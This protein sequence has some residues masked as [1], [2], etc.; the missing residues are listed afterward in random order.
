MSGE[1]KTK[2]FRVKIDKNIEFDDN[3]PSLR[4]K[5]GRELGAF[6]GLSNFKGLKQKRILIKIFFE[7][8]FVYCPLIWMFHTRKIN[9]NKNHSKKQPLVTFKEVPLKFL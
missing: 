7:S 9:R 4:K 1:C 8:Q 2:F 3:L 6:A 5:A